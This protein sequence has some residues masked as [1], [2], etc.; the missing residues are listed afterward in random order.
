MRFPVLGDLAAM[1][2]LNAEFH[3]D[4]AVQSRID[5]L[6]ESA[7]EGTLG[8]DDHDEYEAIVGA[9]GFVSILKLKAQRQ[10]KSNDRRF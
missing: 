6:S 7:N 2:R 1:L 3:V 5:T 10:L 8:E 4:P 9:A